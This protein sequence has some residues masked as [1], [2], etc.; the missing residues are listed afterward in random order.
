MGILAS[1]TTWTWWSCQ[2][3]RMHA[4]WS[5]RSPTSSSRR[6]SSSAVPPDQIDIMTFLKGVDLEAAWARR[7]TGVIDDVDVWFVSKADLVANKRAVGR[8]EDLADIARLG[9]A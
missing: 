3:K 6:P 9:D 4:P 8:P 5:P 2:T 7:V 1:R